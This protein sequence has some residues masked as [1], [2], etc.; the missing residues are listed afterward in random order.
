PSGRPDPRP[1]APLDDGCRLRAPPR[2]RLRRRAARGGAAGGR[3]PARAPLLQCWDRGRTGPVRPG[4]ARARP[5]RRPPARAPARL[6]PARA[7]LRH[8]LARRILVPGACDRPRAVRLQPDPEVLEE[9]L[10]VL[11]IGELVAH[12]DPV[13]VAHPGATPGQAERVLP[14][15]PAQ[16]V[17]VARDGGEDRLGDLVGLGGIAE[18]GREQL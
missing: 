4:R 2:P 14:D 9:A 8:G 3:D 16:A 18:A 1:A 17:L 15:G 10:V 11:L 12:R 13:L 6:G 7:G 5:R